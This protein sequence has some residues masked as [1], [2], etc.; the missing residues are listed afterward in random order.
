MQA[1]IIAGL[2]R[3]RE[4]IGPPCHLGAEAGCVGESV[5]ARQQWAIRRCG[6]TLSPEARGVKSMKRLLPQPGAFGS[7]LLVAYGAVY[8]QVPPRLAAL[9]PSPLMKKPLSS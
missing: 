5:R 4:R 1:T 9:F 8:A 2:G 3:N 6:A 7:R